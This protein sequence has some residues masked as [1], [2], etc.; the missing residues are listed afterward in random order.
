MLLVLSLLIALVQSGYVPPDSCI[1]N[2]MAG[3][4]GT[5]QFM[6]GATDELLDI[7]Y[8]VVPDA[9]GCL[10]QDCAL[11][12]QYYGV[13]CHSSFITCTF[14]LSPFTFHHLQKHSPSTAFCP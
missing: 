9:M 10:W 8:T 11:T 7:T 5:P 1:K 13:V 6:C 14:H 2:C 12:A 3:R 4:T